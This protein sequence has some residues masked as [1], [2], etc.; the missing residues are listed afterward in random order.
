MGPDQ[1]VVPAGPVDGLDRGAQGREPIL[2]A[3]EEEEDLSKVR[4]VVDDAPIVKY[5]NALITQAPNHPGER[6]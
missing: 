3:G 4:E 1:Q 5:V 6:W 2:D